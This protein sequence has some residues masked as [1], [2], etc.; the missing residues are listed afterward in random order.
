MPD[1]NDPPPET[2]F[3][4][5]VF[6]RTLFDAHPAPTWAFDEQTLRFLA[7]NNAVVLKYGYTREEL[8]GLSV[9]DVLPA[10]D[11]ERLAED[12]AWGGPGPG[13]VLYWEHRTKAGALVPLE[14][15][16]TRFEHAGRHAR[17]V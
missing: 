16:V 10:A 3:D 17:L 8:L 9:R 5:G 6:Y 12:L 11:V 1:G 4:A 14:V 7:V 15:V 2:H 13:E